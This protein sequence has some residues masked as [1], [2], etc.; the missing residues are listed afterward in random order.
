M[1][2]G[3]DRSRL[4]ARPD[5]SGPGRRRA[6]T[7]LTDGWVRGLF[8]DAGGPGIGAAL[9]AV[10]GYGRS[11]LSPGSDLDL[12]LLVPG[13]ATT[14]QAAE[15]ASA[16]WYPIW[17]AGLRLDHAMRTPVEARR[18]A[19]EDLRAL[20]GMLDLRHVAG[21]D[22]V[23][24]ALREAVLA[25][26]RGFARRRLP[27]LFAGCAER[28]ARS[29]D[30][31]FS[32]EPDLKE[33]RG[34]L[35]DLVSLRAVAASWVADV[36]HEGLDEARRS[37]L[38][39]RDAVHDVT[40][41]PSD[42][43]VLQD[44]EAVAKRL[45]LLDDDALL[46][47]VAGVGRSVAFA[48]DE[49]AFRVERTLASRGRLVRLGLRRIG[50]RAPLADGVVE[51]DGEV[52]L[53][54]DADPAEDPSLVLRAA[55]AAA[56]AGLRLAPH[57]VQRLAA[58]ST[59]LPE[60][61]P[62]AA[63]D[64]LLS[65]LGA[66]R[67]AIPVWE[68]LDQAGITSRLLPDWE[69]VRS[70]PQRNAVHRFTVDR[71]LVEAAVGAAAYARQVDRPD[72]LLV[73]ALLHDIGKGWPGDHCEAGV[74][75]VADLAPRLGFA[76]DDVQVLV[77]LVRHHLLLP[78]TATRRD[79]DD[80]ATVAHVAASVRTIEVLDL[81]HALT[82]ADGLATGPAA[83][84]EW[85]AALIVDL[86]ERTRAMLGGHEVPPPADLAA[87]HGVLVRARTLAVLVDSTPADGLEVTVVAPDAVGLLGQVAG[88]LSLN[89]LAVRSASTQ[90]E[91]G[92]AVQ[93][94]HVLPDFG[95]PA[96][97]ERLRADLHRAVQGTL[98]VSARLAEREQSSSRRPGVAVP[99][100]RVDVVPGASATAT[101]LEVRAHDR[102]GLLHR[103]GASLAACAVD[104]RSA[105]VSTLGS[106]VVDVFYVVGPDGSPLSDDRARAVALELRAA[107]A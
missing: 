61:W 97:V 102:P 79:L 33:S 41:R 100:P 65:L 4:L 51:Q 60:P 19:S 16:V 37:L 84:T 1:A 64:G 17:D 68:A 44:Q 2:F 18:I 101:V 76:P 40:G 38:D 11:E 99:P 73:G 86:V 30:L 9:V 6:L 49:A 75:V 34:G 62:R 78:D 31:A 25:D 87:A 39:A 103:I 89:R 23:S 29:G 83:W 74:A 7:E 107:L 36:R 47:Q 63:L 32:L 46:R 28:A 98:D 106:E 96:P 95:E 27:E 54:R 8:D 56:Q 59:P 3:D 14:A 12:L 105:R 81:L 53:A 21:D 52:V 71:H 45:G 88:V 90:S 15:V 13:T 70:R 94:W 91:D 10:G 24:A 5:L 43:L 72:L 35:R 85:K 82:E 69:R 26:W 57:T 48:L 67:P 58:Q 66:G 80:P 55:A 22:A 92:M 104:V 77:T 42:R 93:V 50:S 20:L